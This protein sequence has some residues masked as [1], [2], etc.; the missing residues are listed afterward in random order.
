MYSKKVFK[1]YVFLK[2]CPFSTKEGLRNTYIPH[3]RDLILI[4]SLEEI[5]SHN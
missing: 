1:Y 5:R 4:I 3:L 2:T